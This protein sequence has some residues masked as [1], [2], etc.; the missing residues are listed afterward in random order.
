[1]DYSFWVLKEN[2]EK[3]YF[4]SPYYT[5]FKLLLILFIKTDEI[6]K[7]ELTQDQNAGKII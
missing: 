6:H 4:L 7:V 3:N 5:N 1:M 2:R